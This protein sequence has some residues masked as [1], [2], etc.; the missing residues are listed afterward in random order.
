MPD[1]AE[2]RPDAPA[3]ALPDTLRLHRGRIVIPA[4]RPAV[5]VFP[6]AAFSEVAGVVLMLE[7]S[8]TIGAIWCAAPV[9]ALLVTGLL[10]RP[11][12]ELT[13]DGLVQ[14]QY[15]F[16]SLTRWAA[17]DHVGLTRAGN[18]LVLA[19]KLVDGIPPPRRQPAAALL[20]AA[21]R[22]YDGGYFADSMR[23][24]PERILSTVRTFLAD[25][26]LR[27]QLPPARRG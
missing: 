13:R 22:P 17:I 3:A 4:R 27:D 9:M 2:R 15:P 8:T 18:R 1:A 24:D 16:T 12:L 20:R 25:A 11:T 7:V 23:G 10:F 5:L 6:F 21:Q 26:T 19:Y 14:R